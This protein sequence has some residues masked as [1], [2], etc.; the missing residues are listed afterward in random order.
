MTKAITTFDNEYLFLSNFYEANVVFKGLTFKSAEAA[1]Q[2]QKDPNREIEFINLGPMEAKNLARKI[3]IRPD[4]EDI[5]VSIM[6]VIVHKKF[7]QNKGL[8]KKLIHTGDAIL[9]EGN[10]WQDTFW[11]VC[12]NV[13]ENNLGKI[14]MNVRK[15]LQISQQMD[16]RNKS[17]GFDHYIMEVDWEGIQDRH[18]D[19][20]PTG[21][22]VMEYME[23][24][25]FKKV[26]NSATLFKR[27]KT[28]RYVL[29]G[30]THYPEE[31]TPKIQ[32]YYDT[33]EL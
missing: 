20:L 25:G 11:G 3:T 27:G 30:D 31:V 14:L 33:F 10:Y 17:M 23:K 24:N 12:E 5:K 15:K 7:Q 22:L 21:M 8:A 4:W 9:V 2:S 13:G 18:V 32:D 16:R 1:Y 6:E 29:Y 26:E 19:D 28:I